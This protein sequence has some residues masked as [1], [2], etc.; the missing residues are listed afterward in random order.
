MVTSGAAPRPRNSTATRHAI[1]AAARTQFAGGGYR[2]TTVKQI[3][4]A[5]GVSPNLVTRYF[6][7]KDGL[8]LAAADPQ[9][10]VDDVFVGELAGL[11]DRLAASITRRWSRPAGDD[12][13]LLLQR[14]AGERPEAAAA[15]S[16]FL[17]EHSSSPLERYLRSQGVSARDAAERAASIDALVLGMSTRHRVLRADLPGS[18][19]LRRR[20]ARAIQALA[21]PGGPDSVRHTVTPRT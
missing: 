21:E 3:A 17:D 1:L 6:G 12:P 10:A 15:L 9:I 16:Q 8:F 11:G 2:G 20:L 19:T 4:D 13:L 14:A 7:G 5:A 18:A